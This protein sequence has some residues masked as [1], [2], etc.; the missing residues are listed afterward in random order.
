[1]FYELQVSGHAK[2]DLIRTLHSASVIP[3]HDALSKEMEDNAGMRDQLA[4]LVAS[5]EMPQSYWEH[6]V[7]ATPPRAGCPAGLVLPIAIYVD[8]VPYSLTDSVIGFWVENVVAS[9][10][11]LCCLLRKRL[12]CK[13][14]CRGW[15]SFRAVF[16]FLRWSIAALSNG[17]WPT[18]RH[19]LQAWRPI[20]TARAAK[21][22]GPMATRTT[23]P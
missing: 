7:V 17:A 2:H 14:G 4:E 1:M 6:V 16:R 15:C 12:S 20:D 13:C 5:R 22:G 8:A 10:R 11:H 3:P 18:A 23:A 21:A 19:D 9:K